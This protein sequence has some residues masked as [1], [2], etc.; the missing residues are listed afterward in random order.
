MCN[1][2]CRCVKN[3]RAVILDKSLQRPLCFQQTGAKFQSIS[4]PWADTT[5]HAGK[6]IM[7]AFAGIADYAECANMPSDSA[8]VALSQAC[9]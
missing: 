1:N 2:I 3:H 4:Q 7:T 6:L 8:K 9:Q 5:T